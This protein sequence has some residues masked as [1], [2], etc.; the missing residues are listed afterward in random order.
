VNVGQITSKDKK[1]Q[2]LLLIT[3]KIPPFNNN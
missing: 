2:Y 1:N 3:S